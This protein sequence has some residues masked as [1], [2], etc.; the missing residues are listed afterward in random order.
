MPS[1]R[2]CYGGA[3]RRAI[4]GPSRLARRPASP[5]PPQQHLRSASCDGP[6]RCLG[7]FGGSS[8]IVWQMADHVRTCRNPL[9]GKGLAIKFEF[10]LRF[11][12]VLWYKMRRFAGIAR[13]AQTHTRVDTMTWVPSARSC[14]L[15]IGIRGGLTRLIKELS[16]P[17]S[18]CAIC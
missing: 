4:H 13:R 6:Q 15:V 9:Q 1:L 2:H 14:W 5:P 11:L 16:C 10:T 18:T 7:Y 17:K 12:C 3:P 8:K